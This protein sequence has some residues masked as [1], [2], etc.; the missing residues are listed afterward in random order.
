MY[1]GS[2][3]SPVEAEPQSQPTVVDAPVPQP[4]TPESD[5]DVLPVKPEQAAAPEPEP[6]SA[7]QPAKPAQARKST[8]PKAQRRSQSAPGDSTTRQAVS[9][10]YLLARRRPQDWVRSPVRID[11]AQKERL[12]RRITGDFKATGIKF[13]MN[14]YFAAALQA[15]PKDLDGAAEWGE[16]YLEQLGMRTPQTEGTVTRLPKELAERM[17][18][19][20]T[21]M[22]SHAR[23]GLVG[24]IQ[25]A[26]LDR[27]LNALDDEDM[28]ANK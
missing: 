8:N 13:S 21:E 16:A 5:K 25:M 11:L 19:L 18:E 26:A 6:V 27:L 1:E 22:P 17:R 12:R 10:A 7:K 15:L 20:T 14:H 3:G 24:Y 28:A 4:E 9:D 23:Y 2:F